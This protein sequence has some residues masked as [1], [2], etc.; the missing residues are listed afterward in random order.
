MNEDKRA[1]LIAGVEAVRNGF[2]GE[3]G[4]AAK[5]LG[6]GEQILIDENR[7]FP[8]ASSAKIWVLVE[9]FKQVEEGKIT[10]D[11]RVSLTPEDK[12]LGSG[13]LRDLQPGLNLTIR[14]L[15][16]LMIIVSD[17]TAT[18][19]CI[20][21][22]GIDSIRRTMR[23]LGLADSRL[24]NRIDFSLL[25]DD[26][27]AFAVGTCA[28]FARAMEL[29][30][31][32]EILTP[33][34]CES[35]IDIMQRDQHLDFAPRWLPYNPYADELG[36][37]QDIVVANKPGA[38]SGVRADV[39]LV[40]HHATEYVLAIMSDGCG[41]DRWNADNEGNLALATISRM[42]FDYFTA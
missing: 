6:T 20:D 18:N 7:V 41:D 27:G 30:A 33:A 14:D 5:N 3:L 35:I 28:D 11:R 25:L 26:A 9:V 31:K 23:E 13:V 39:L 8:T 24:N 16:T 22:L 21:L 4:V 12:V 1:A 15:A 34:S 42:I 40:R 10:L 32:H 17:N 29:I 38:I 19:M 2:S 37:K 36:V